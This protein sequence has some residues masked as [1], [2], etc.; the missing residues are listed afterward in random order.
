MQ[1]AAMNPMCIRRDQIPAEAIEKEKAILIEQGKQE[2]KPEK[3]LENIVKGRLEKYYQEVCLEEQV[4]VK[5]G[6]K[7]IKDRLADLTKKLGKPVQIQSFERFRL[8]E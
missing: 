8:G 1:A 7:T 3:V 4:F 6:S 5:D 2:G